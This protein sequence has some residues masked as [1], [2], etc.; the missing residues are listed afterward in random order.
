MINLNYS[1]LKE[2]HR[3][4]RENYTDEFSIRIHRS[5]SWINRAE[6][7]D[8]DLDA[9]FIFYWIA[10]NAAYSEI[11]SSN[12]FNSERRIYK[13]FFEKI[14]KLDNKENI[15]NAIWKEFSGSIRNLLDNHFI[16]GPF[17]NFQNGHEGFDDWEVKFSE[18]RSKALKALQTKN[19]LIILE[20]LCDRLYT[21]RNQIL[22]GGSTWNGK[23]NRS[24]VNDGQSIISFLIPNLLEIMMDNP[25]ENWGKLSF[26]IVDN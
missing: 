16:F 11:H 8:E 4:K 3:A 15:Y 19:T 26:P 10:F 14:L 2:I 24:Q 23:V 6:K 20:I 21:L 12:Y 9:R 7:K 5:L 22:H 1:K 13:D 17:W 25:N 18:S